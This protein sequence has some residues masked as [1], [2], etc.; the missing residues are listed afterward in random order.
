MK[1][2]KFSIL[3]R[4][5][6]VVLSLMLLFGSLPVSALDGDD[7]EPTAV[8]ETQE[9]TQIGEE[10]TEVQQNQD[11]T[12][13]T[14]SEFPTENKPGGTEPAVSP[15]EA[16]EDSDTIKIKAFSQGGN[17]VN[18][19][20]PSLGRIEITID[21][22]D[23]E[24]EDIDAL[25]VVFIKSDDYSASLL[26]T[27]NLIQG[28]DNEPD[29]VTLG[30]DSA[31]R[32]VKLN[33]R[34]SSAPDLT[35][36]EYTVV[37]R[38]GHGNVEKMD[39]LRLTK[40]PGIR[41]FSGIPSDWTKDSVTVGIH[42]NGNI[43]YVDSV[44]FKEKNGPTS[45]ATYS[46]GV[47]YAAIQKYAAANSYSFTVIDVAGNKNTATLN[48]TIKIDKDKPDLSIVKY[49]DGKND[50]VPGTTWLTA[51]QKV[52]AVVKAEDKND[53]VPQ[54]GINEN[55]FKL[56]GKEVAVTKDGDNYRIELSDPTKISEV[57]VKDTAENVAKV[58]TAPFS[59]DST[60]PVESDIQV[61]FSPAETLAGKF[62]NALSFGL[63]YNDSIK[64]TVKVNSNGES[65]IADITVK[66]INDITSK[67]NGKVLDRKDITNDGHGVFSAEYILSAQNT[68]YNLTIEATDAVGNESSIIP[69]SEIK[70]I[71]IKENALGEDKTLYEVVATNLAPNMEDEDFVVSGKPINDFYVTTDGK[72]KVSLKITDPLSGLDGDV[73][74][75]FAKTS[76]F[77]KTDEQYT[78]LPEKVKDKDVKRVLHTDT[79]TFSEKRI[80]EDL[81]FELP[82]DLASGDYTVLAIAK[83]N[84]GKTAE[85]PRGIKI[86]N[87]GPV[88]SDA[89]LS[90]DGW[91]KDEITV[92]FKVQDDFAGVNADD[93]SVKKP[94]GGTLTPTDN[95]DGTYS[96]VTKVNGDYIA[97]A[98]DKLGNSSSEL[99]ITVSNFDDKMP[100]IN[101][102][103]YEPD[104]DKNWTSSEVKVSF[105]VTDNSNASVNLTID[106]GTVIHVEGNGKYWF[107]ANANRVYKITATDQAVNS[108]TVSTKMILFDNQSPQIEKVVF[109]KGKGNFKKFGIYDNEIIK[110]TVFVRSPGNAPIDEILLK[111]GSDKI[112]HEGTI[113]Q[114]SED[115]K[116]YSLTF[117]LKISEKAYHLSV[118]AKNKSQLNASANIEDLPLYIEGDETA[119]MIEEKYKNAFELVVTDHKP[120]IDFD[121][122]IKSYS[123]QPDESNAD[124][125]VFAGAGGG[126][127]SATVTDDLS[128]VESIDSVKFDGQKVDAVYQI[129]PDNKTVSVPVSYT[130]DE[131]LSSGEHTF[132]ITAK[133]NAGNSRTLPYTFYL[134]QTAP[135]GEYTVPDKW[136]NQHIEVTLSIDDDA[137]GLGY[138]SGIDK[139]EVDGGDVKVEKKSD[140]EYTFIAESRKDYTISMTDKLGN[141]GTFTVAAE[142]ILFDNT[143]PELV[144]DP[145]TGSE[146]TYNNNGNTTWVSK[147]T[148]VTVSF[149]LTDDLSGVDTESIKIT[150]DS[151]GVTYHDKDG[152]SCVKNTET[153]EVTCSFR[154]DY[155]QTYTVTVTDSVMLEGDDVNK[156]TFEVNDKGKLKVDGTAPE[157]NSVTFES[158]ATA[159]EKILNVLSFGLYSNNDIKMT[160]KATDAAPSSGIANI[161]AEYNNSVTIKAS[162]GWSPTDASGE[163][164]VT[165]TRDFIIKKSNEAIDPGN[166]KLTATDNVG[167]DSDVIS[168]ADTDKYVV[169]PNAESA[170]KAPVQDGFEIVASDEKPEIGTIELEGNGK[171]KVNENIW[172]IGEENGTEVT[173]TSEITAK[174]TKLHD[175]QVYLNGKRITE[176]VGGAGQIT[177]FINNSGDPISSKTISFSTGGFDCV[178]RASSGDAENV[179]KIVAT[180]N[181]TDGK[182]VVSEDS[183]TFYIDDT[184][185]EITSVRFESA[186]SA[187]DSVLNV[188]TF[189]LYSN[190]KIKMTVNV[191][192][193]SDS[194][195]IYSSGVK[196]ISLNNTGSGKIDAGE[197]D[198]TGDSI[199]GSIT[200]SRT[201][202]YTISNAKFDPSLIT[203]GVTDNVGNKPE[204][205]SVATL[206]QEGKIFTKNNE[207]AKIFDKDKFEIVSTSQ[208]PTVSDIKLTATPEAYSDGSKVWYQGNT[209]DEVG[210]KFT[211]ED[212]L[213][214]LHSV[215]TEINGHNIIKQIYTGFEN[216]PANTPDGMDAWVGENEETYSAN[217]AQSDVTGY[218]HRISESASYNQFA[219]EVCN[220]S[221]ITVNK[222]SG[223]FYI[224]DVAPYIT[225]FSFAGD[226]YSDVYADDENGGLN[227]AGVELKEYGFYFKSTTDVTVTASDFVEKTNV[228]GS[229]VKYIGF[230]FVDINGET[231][232]YG[233]RAVDKNSQATFTVNAD[234]KGQIF[235]YAVDHVTNKGSEITPAGL[236]VESGSAHSSHSDASI[237]FG[238][239]NYHGKDNNG[240]DL[241]SGD[242]T[243]SF[244]ISDSISGLRDAYYTVTNGSQVVDFQQVNVS[245]G[246]SL[247]N[248]SWR[249]AQRENGTNL[250]TRMTLTDSISASQFNANNLVVTLT[251]H[252]RAGYTIEAKKSLSIDITKPKIEVTFNPSDPVNTDS[253]NNYYSST[254]TATITVTERNFNPNDFDWS[255]MIAIEG[256]VPSYAAGANWSTSYSNYTDDSQHTATVAFADDGKYEVILNFTD[257]AGN[258]ADQVDAGQFYID[259]TVPTISVSYSPDTEYYSGTVTATVTIVEHNFNPDGKYLTLTPHYYAPDQST[260]KSGP[261]LAAWSSGGDT[262]TAT[263]TFSEDGKYAFDIAFKDMALNDAQSYTGKTFYVDQ[264][265]PEI[266]FAEAIKDGQ[267]YDT[268][269]QPGFDVFDFNYAG[270]ESVNYTLTKHYYDFNTGKQTAEVI[271]SSS[272]KA[273][274]IEGVIRQLFTYPL[275]EKT[276]GNDG[277]Y[278]LT[279]SATD[280]A[281]NVSEPAS[282]TFSVNCFG[283]VFLLASD[284]TVQLAESGYTSDAP[285]ILIKEINVN[286]LK[287]Q[288]MTL[289]YNNSNQKLSDKDYSITSSGGGDQWYEYLYKISSDMFENEGSYTVTASSTDAKLGTVT[290]NRTVNTV[291]GE[292]AAHKNCPVSF[293]VDKTAPSVTINGVEENGAYSEAE[294]E[295]QITCLDDNLD[296]DSVVLKIN[297]E[298]VD[299][300]SSE[301]NDSLVGQLDINHTI[302]ASGQQTDYKVEVEAK[303]YA[304]VTGEGSVDKFTLSATWL[305]M[306]FHNTTAVIITSVVL[307][308]LIALAIF[309]I[310]KKRRQ[311][312]P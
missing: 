141:T 240:L 10:A 253:G 118:E 187:A 26:D 292:S 36:G 203:L 93:V 124:R 131:K 18:Y 38:D 130:F 132:E 158:A 153:G 19:A 58:N 25:S 235:A 51:N 80:A 175:I 105:E 151:N 13:Q 76:E 32:T 12:T 65:D 215:K 78:R 98:V 110:A 146:F 174:L 40:A 218:L 9:P 258:K 103:K 47:Y 70:K 212:K 307:A 221:G 152:Y 117:P 176:Q 39:V 237:E 14:A 214:K 276:E 173:V 135:K 232:D 86:D 282:L 102:T 261:T 55:S 68:E 90:P 50:I 84:S 134:D 137:D 185:P 239:A 306:F 259:K 115:K 186:K 183:R 300:E 181:N 309:L 107:M 202:T 75:Y 106:D 104:G 188:L 33:L 20:T 29:W 246:G 211:A 128:G 269:V 256:S 272:V 155:Y 164:D 37:V 119:R 116:L 227:P 28:F 230:R 140:G 273:E 157:I 229:G 201:Y 85:F 284:E 243:V 195:P 97:T 172:F 238:S 145:E 305:T 108:N 266:T 267:A 142:D 231:Y 17:L 87:D 180:G 299:L 77:E 96:F 244:T 291:D 311:E 30:E 16:A 109:E 95:G 204:D 198:R 295:I 194:I 54:S 257:M 64:M 248:N 302:L 1:M 226:G 255:K 57:S 45:T 4:V 41:S 127:V 35:D 166:I 160:V 91:T 61:V 15:T 73:A 265:K 251:A 126:T 287:E 225:E 274:Y 193:G 310:L 290:T 254:R 53:D 69:L 207:T 74:L 150:G 71:Y 288:S 144:K 129:D 241:F 92:T 99:K 114:D 149:K 206:N 303:D 234:F 156:A 60:A 162:E 268:Q 8:Q 271:D 249:I 224:D 125:K 21:K 263:L 279:V 191:V 278:V 44:T 171:Q 48:Q 66:D 63:Y 293:I 6:A 154:A 112:E 200:A 101:I 83:N 67:D 275:F 270:A 49:T 148:G 242:V 199:T 286:Q 82:A 289:S 111:N 252:D 245:N 308:A 46:D 260:V 285:D 43:D 196:T 81:E 210:M 280:R 178:H 192:D 169:Y 7:P 182:E 213:S 122:V 301:I 138:Y 296:K 31:Q 177:D 163:H 165:V 168:A 133:N 72:Q 5:L 220:N 120:A 11:E 197:F 113:A 23:T 139:V 190:D 250:I 2:S 123:S 89:E 136:T 298:T 184:K 205:V 88:L 264:T 170:V 167:Y 62:L 24:T 297:G 283:S 304:G 217:T 143:A 34:N 179:V 277:V 228:E 161:T 147:E 27:D 236:I 189:G 294:R 233:E 3:L 159:T 262:H 56:D 52:Y 223:Q 247:N 79:D 281:G 42:I 216:E 94:D 100:D 222:K 22:G 208:K 312:N 59:I 219:V 209:S 121:D